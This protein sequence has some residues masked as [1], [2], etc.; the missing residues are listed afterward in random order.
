MDS[1]LISQELSKR[2]IS[3][4]M[5]CRSHG[6]KYH[7]MGRNDLRFGSDWKFMTSIFAVLHAESGAFG[8]NASVKRRMARHQIKN[9]AKA[10]GKSAT[11]LAKLF[12]SDA[13][14]WDQKLHPL[15][16]T[17]LSKLSGKSVVI[18]Y[19][20]P[21]SQD[22]TSIAYTWENAISGIRRI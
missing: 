13:C 14:K 12:V 19:N 22:A 8:R 21:A 15:R 1:R 2:V 17:I 3:R 9:E 4:E 11:I 16:G 10:W 18:L 6:W 7:W 5:A 20:Y